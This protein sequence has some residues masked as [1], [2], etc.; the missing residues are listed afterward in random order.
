MSVRSCQ[1]ES[2]F[3][4]EYK[5]QPAWQQP[6]NL[7]R[8]DTEPHVILSYLKQNFH[9]K[10]TREMQIEISYPP[11]F[12]YPGKFYYFLVTCSACEQTLSYLEFFPLK[13]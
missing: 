5:F 7:K 9:V 12:C 13:V 6:Y 2:Y 4:S 8:E 1:T 10:I 3:I 11:K